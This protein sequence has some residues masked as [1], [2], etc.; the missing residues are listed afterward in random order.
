MWWLLQIFACASVEAEPTAPSPP[1][2][3]LVSLDTLRADRLGAWGNPDGLTPNLDRLA[4]E[5][6]VFTQAWSQATVTAPSHASMFSSRYPTELLGAGRAPAFRDNPLLAEV[7]RTYGYQT[8]AFVGGADL[9]PALGMTAGFDTYAAP[10]P[11]GSLWR[12]TPLALDWLDQRDRERP[13]FL[14]LHG[15]D[16]HVHYLKPT[17]FGYL[18]A[19]R[20]YDGVGQEAVRTGTEQL[21]HGRYFRDVSPIQKVQADFLRHDSPEAILALHSLADAPGSR[22]SRTTATDE[23]HVRGVYDGGVSYLDTAMG[24]LLAALDE[25]GLLETTTLVVMSDHGEQLGEHGYFNHANGAGDEE[26]HVVLLV[27]P[28][29]PPTPGRRVDA[30]VSLLDVMPTLLDLAGA[31]PP[32]RARGQSLRALLSVP[33]GSPPQTPEPW[34][35][36]GYA[37]TQGNDRMRSVSVRSATARLTY[38]GL[39]ASAELLPDLIAAAALDGPGFSTLPADLDLSTRSTLRDVLVAWLRSLDVTREAQTEALPP[40]LRDALRARGYWDAE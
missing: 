31:V 35:G 12:T 25:R 28:A 37:F 7:L 11:F 6:V 36:R 9:D 16:A 21:V 15:Y 23:A 39:E 5:S 22:A 33:A 13:F 3:L 19:E 27:R 1:N 29:G 20:D 14:F 40:A 34:V 18:H 30:P 17:P 8:G 24:L 32:A 2:L 38:T 4:A 26:S 10:E